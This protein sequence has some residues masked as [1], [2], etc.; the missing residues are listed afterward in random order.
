M[1][2][3]LPDDGVFVDEVAQ[4]GFAARLAFPV[5]KPRTFLSP[6]YQDNLGWGYGTA[7]GVKA[8]KPGTPV[9]SIAGDG[10]FLYQANELATAVRH[11][12]GVVAVV[13]DNGLFGNVR[14]IQRE[15]FGNRIIAS[16]LTNPDFRKY[17]ESFGVAAYRAKTAR[18]L[19]QA[20]EK[21]LALGE[22]ALI[23]VPCGEMPS[24][25]DMILMKRVRG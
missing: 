17:A 9:L 6:G 23:H 2:H 11:K 22:P 16:D 19:Q 7:L 13:F 12:L 25:W 24:P 8:I 21:A 18:E 5:Y 15:Q 4:L 10:G 20:L 3:A 1:R 14:L